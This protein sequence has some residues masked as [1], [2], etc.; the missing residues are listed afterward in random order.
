MGDT[1]SGPTN[2][3]VVGLAGALLD[4][5]A[6]YEL[7]QGLTV[8]ASRAVP[9]AKAVSI[10]VI[11]GGRYRTSN[12]TGPEALAIDEAQYEEGDGPCLE[13]MRSKRQLM[14]TTAETQA[15]WRNFV[16]Q[17]RQEGVGSVLSTPLVGSSGESIGAL[18]I[19]GGDG[20]DLGSAERCS[21][22]I[23]G[24]HAA[25]LVGRALALQSS[26]QLNEQ[27]RQAVESR[28][29]IGAAKGILMQRQGCTRDEAFDI[30]RRASQ[31]ENRKLRELA[32]EL[33][34]RVEYRAA[35]AAPGA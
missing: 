28:E 30:L 14:S 8:L 17:A 21:A 24:D 10:T 23:I 9:D 22:Q 12:S 5:D 27:L 20:S 35:K 13:A 3:H 29:V 32:E 4:D 6:L 1:H 19:Y 16:E 11:E 15:R 7:L 18:N 33:V 2:Q 31:R 26:E 25:I 34:L